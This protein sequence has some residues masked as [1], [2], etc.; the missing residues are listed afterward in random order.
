MKILISLRDQSFTRTKSVGI[1]NVALGL[2]RG[3]AQLPEVRELHV[4]ANRECA[5][6]LRDAGDKVILHGAEDEPPTRFRRVG[7]DQVGVVR[8]IRRIAP[9]WAILPKGVA[10]QFLWLGRTK[11]AC[12]LHDL[13]WEYYLKAAKS[14]DTPYPVHELMYFRHL[15]LHTLRC[16]DAVFTSTQF[17]AERFAAYVPQAKAHVVG[18]GFDDPAQPMRAARGRDILF[19]ASP[20]PHKLT[21]L[22]L[23]RLEA[24]WRRRPDRESIGI[25]LLGGLPQGLSLPP[26]PQWQHHGRLAP[27]AMQQLLTEQCCAAVYFSAYEGYGMPPTE[28]L[29][30]GIPCIASDIPAIAEH[31]PKE[32]LFANDSADSFARALEHACNPALS[33]STPAYPT[34]TEVAA[35]ACGIMAERG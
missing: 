26:E 21:A 4:L 15:H 31:H 32:L 17:N 20:Y 34:W 27:E 16:A 1:F 14:G 8:A 6:L 7:W 22:G 30:A 5:P 24:W 25:H 9:D 28:C 3:L 12:F 23:Q 33:L 10:P 29:R 35:K 18:L 19:Y 11:L 2:T 13:N